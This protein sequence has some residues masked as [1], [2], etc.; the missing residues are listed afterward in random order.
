MLFTVSA[1]LYAREFV[2]LVQIAYLFAQ[3]QAFYSVLKTNGIAEDRPGHSL[4][5]F[6]GRKDALWPRGKMGSIF[7]PREKVAEACARGMDLY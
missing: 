3:C 7:L 4:C 1:A 2:T 5:R 6:T